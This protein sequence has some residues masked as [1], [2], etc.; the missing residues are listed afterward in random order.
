MRL[1]FSSFGAIL[2]SV[3]CSL[4][5]AH[6]ASAQTVVESRETSALG[7]TIYPN[8]LAMVTEVRRV[9]V[10]KGISEIRFHGV[11]D[12]IV[13]ETAVLQSFE[14]LRL[15]GNFNSDLISRAALLKSA[16]GETMTL[17]RL[18]P[19]TGEFDLH[20][21]E[22]VSAANIGQNIQGAVFKTDE[23]VEALQ[24]SGLGEALIFSTL[25][26]KLNPIPMLSMTVNAAE[27]GPKDI[28]LTYLTRGMGWEA[29]YRMDVKSGPEEEET[30]ATLLGWLTLTNETSKSF[31]D[32]E[33]SVVAG[34]VNRAPQWGPHRPN[35]NAGVFIP[36]CGD[37]VT[38]RSRDEIVVTGARSRY[39]ET[40]VVQEA[41]TELISTPAGTVE[42]AVPA[43]TKFVSVRAAVREELG[44]YKL[45]RAPQPVTVSAHQTKQIAFL[46]KQDVQFEKFHKKTV[47]F[48][49]RSPWA[50]S[51][52]PSIVEYDIDN[53]LDGNLASP[54]PK[55]TLRIMSE[56]KT[57]QNLFT[58]EGLVRNLAVDLPFEVKIAESFLAMT[59]Y[60]LETVE[61]GDYLALRLSTDFHNASAVA[62][63]AEVEIKDLSPAS[64]S[65]SN[66]ERAPDEALPTYR[67]EVAPESKQTLIVDLAFERYGEFIHNSQRYNGHQKYRGG[68]SISNYRFSESKTENPILYEL[69]KQRGGE[70]ITFT[71]FEISKKNL[72]FRGVER[73]EKFV[74][75]NLHEVPLSFR[76][77]YDG[78]GEQVTVIE[79]S[80][81]PETDSDAV[82]EL[83]VPAKSELVLTTTTQLPR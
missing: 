20:D 32:A 59:E 73:E 56:S 35:S 83:T 48:I 50:T 18:N 15:E 42:R 45:Y 64:I 22:L 34:R 67:F 36:T 78:G 17:R 46:L 5:L 31:E 3:W 75:K 66:F 49:K 62:I 61:S 6:P 4:I 23:G 60:D 24:C 74:F 55:G 19:V 30:G 21:A 76:F 77:R 26:D 72:I 16:V 14:G 29:D 7:L 8:N 40:V 44:D 39:T 27:A 25:P 9:D 1:C 63:T 13:T 57:G 37:S 12:M 70:S 71:A 33:L 54:L 53:S 51:P 58:G 69:G 38:R 11:T 68:V 81:P 79:S 43:V 52:R 80:I 82:W 28:T 10:P 2:L 41:S 47:E 65:S